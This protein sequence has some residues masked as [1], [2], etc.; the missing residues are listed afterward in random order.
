MQQALAVAQQERGATQQELAT[1]QAG[2]ITT[3]D[4]L[5]TVQQA[6]AVAQQERGATQR[7]L[8]NAQ[9]GLITT[10]DELATV[11][12]ELAETQD[13]LAGEQKRNRALQQEFAAAQRDAKEREINAQQEI[14]T[15]HVRLDTVQKDHEALKAVYAELGGRHKEVSEQFSLVLEKLVEL[16]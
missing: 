6:L 1:A 14:A 2:L 7:E 15:L 4:E 9:A 12:Q 3:Q 10:Q 13:E 16:S 5:A 8:T 11:R